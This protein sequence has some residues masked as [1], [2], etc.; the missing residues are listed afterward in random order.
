MLNYHLLTFTKVN[1]FKKILPGTLI[2]LSNGL[3]PDQDLYSVGPDLGPSVCKGY[4]QTTK[5]TSS[6]E[7]V[8]KNIHQAER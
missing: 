7:R 6:K 5:V 1:F 8:K 2:R 4:Q 3:A